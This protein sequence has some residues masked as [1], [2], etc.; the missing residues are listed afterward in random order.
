MFHLLCF[1]PRWLQERSQEVDLASAAEKVSFLRG[2]AEAL[3]RGLSREAGV[4]RLRV[5]TFGALHGRSSFL[6][7]GSGWEWQ[8]FD[9]QAPAVPRTNDDLLPSDVGALSQDDRG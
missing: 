5:R 1:R 8:E 7:T 6:R 9:A 3:A 2:L 4:V